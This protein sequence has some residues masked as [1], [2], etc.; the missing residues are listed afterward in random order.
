MTTHGRKNC[1]FTSLKKPPERA[2]LPSPPRFANSPQLK[3]SASAP[4][5]YKLRLLLER[6]QWSDAHQNTRHGII[7]QTTAS[8]D[9]QSDPLASKSLPEL[10]LAIRYVKS[11]F[12]RLLSDTKGPAR[13]SKGIHNNNKIENTHTEKQE[14][15][16]QDTLRPRQ[17]HSVQLQPSTYTAASVPALKCSWCGS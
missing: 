16:N 9:G 10:Y 13:N 6:P 5:P 14:K 8:S 11:C 1:S 2:P 17:K 12:L 4:I 15:T 3:R 7:Q